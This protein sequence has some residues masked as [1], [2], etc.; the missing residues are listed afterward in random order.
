MQ[1]QEENRALRLKN[2]DVVQMDDTGGGVGNFNVAADPG[3]ETLVLEETN[4]IKDNVV[5]GD[6]RQTWQY[7]DE[8]SYIRGNALREGEDPYARNKFNQQASDLLPSNREIPD[9]RGLA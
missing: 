4:Y 7:F 6:S 5:G 2:V 8:K 9:T 3:H 1:Q